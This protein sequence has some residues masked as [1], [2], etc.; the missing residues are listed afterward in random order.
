MKTITFHLHAR[1][2]FQNEYG[3]WG[4]KISILLKDSEKNC[5][6]GRGTN[7][8]TFRKQRGTYPKDSSS[9]SFSLL[10]WSYPEDLAESSVELNRVWH[11]WRKNE[12]ELYDAHTVE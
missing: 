12:F 2:S 6:E 9:D 1:S 3:H 7:E 5:K 10:A 4:L 8:K 11:W